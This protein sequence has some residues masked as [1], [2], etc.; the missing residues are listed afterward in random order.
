MHNMPG[1][2][3]GKFAIRP[4]PI[5]AATD[6]FTIDITGAG[7]HAAKPHRTVD[8]I[9]VGTAIG[10][11]AAD[12]RLALGRSD[13][14]GGRRRVTQFHAGE[15]YNIIAETA[16]VA[17]TVRTLKPE[18]RDLAERRMREI[19]AGIAAAHGARSRS[20]TTATIR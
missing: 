17:G 15:A 8:P 14:I 2:P 3:V 11:G 1:L 7:G 9:I 10:P 5:M 18:I 20:T 16:E 6:E 4:G 12:D 13:R 19:V